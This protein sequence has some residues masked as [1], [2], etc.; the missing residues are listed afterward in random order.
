MKWLSKNLLLFLLG[1]LSLGL[2]PFNPPHIIG[3]LEWL[4]G[5]GAF[6]GPSPM[7]GADWFDLFLHGT[8]WIL[9][10]LSLGSYLILKAKKVN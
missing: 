5:G 7:K 6:S 9:L 1:A 2:A 4:M 10:I 3:K 8:P